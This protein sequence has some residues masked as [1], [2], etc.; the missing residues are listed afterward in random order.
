MTPLARARQAADLAA[1]DLA[2]AEQGFID[3]KATFAV[4]RDRVGSDPT[5]AAIAARHAAQEA[6]VVASDV[7]RAAKQR[8]VDAALA[9]EQAEK[10][11][12]EQLFAEAA[13]ASDRQ[14]AFA[15]LH[16]TIAALAKLRSYRLIQWQSGMVPA[17]LELIDPTPDPYVP[18]LA[19]K[20][21]WAAYRKRGFELHK[22]LRAV[23]S[24]VEAH[25]VNCERA[26]A[27]AAKL[28]LPA[29]RRIAIAEREVFAL[30]ALAAMPDPIDRNWL[31][32]WARL[33]R[34]DVSVRSMAEHRGVD[35]RRWYELTVI[36]ADGSDALLALSPPPVHVEHVDPT[37]RVGNDGTDTI[38]AFLS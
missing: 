33:F 17:R 18:P 36:L 7:R 26:R 35:M 14:A 21:A 32:A 38:P 27:L 23:R 1:A 5:A 25:A 8:V 37:R 6:V 3:A 16:H 2:A 31:G 34:I 15:Q 11:A 13:A 12:D 24:Q 29:P 10:T 9:A 19:S 30:A 4:A 20:A 28:G 22:Y